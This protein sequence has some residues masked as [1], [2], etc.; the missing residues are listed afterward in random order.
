MGH[1]G[2]MI[3]AA[4]APPPGP[5]A[6]HRETVRPEWIDYN[7]HMNV[8]YYV[9]AFDHATETLF[10]TL[11]IGEDYVRAAKCSLFVVDMHV[12]YEQELVAGDRLRFET[13]ILGHD[14]RLHLFH[15]D[16]GYRQ[17]LAK[18]PSVDPAR[19]HGPA[20]RRRF[21]MTSAPARRLAD[22]HRLSR[23]PQADEPW[24]RQA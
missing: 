18:P 15:R 6:L 8:A 5:L 2:T 10:E 17:V 13:Q 24:A 16:P 9:L 23:P 21:P 3:D 1:T 22:A 12:T 19:Q 4:S 20:P 14:Q 7:G 11:G